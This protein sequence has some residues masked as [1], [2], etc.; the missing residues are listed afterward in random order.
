M[1]LRVIPSTLEA[2]N[3]FVRA[4]HRHHGPRQ[5]HMFSLAIA[6]GGGHSV[7]GIAI[8]GRPCARELQDGATVEILR[9]CTDGVRNG[10]SALY[11]AARRASTEL[12]YARGLTYILDDESGTSLKAAGYVYLWT[13]KGGLWDTPARRRERSGP[14]C[15][16]Q[17]WGWGDFSNVK[18]YGAAHRDQGAA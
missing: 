17:A 15:R 18:A 9:V 5:G 2:A 8:V 16:K 7:R 14:S 4:H 3:A 1:T 6:D 10:C 12:G 13:T 11:G